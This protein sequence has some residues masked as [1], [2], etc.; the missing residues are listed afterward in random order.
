MAI[1]KFVNQTPEI[2]AIDGAIVRFKA[3]AAFEAPRAAAV[4]ADTPPEQR[5][6]AVEDLLEFGATVAATAKTSAH[7][8]MMEGKVEELAARLGDQLKDADRRSVKNIEKVLSEFQKDLVKILSAREAVLQKSVQRGARFEDI[9]SARLPLLARGIGQV[10]HCAGS[11]GDNARN[12]GDYIVTVESALAG[13][14]VKIVVEAK[15]QKA[16]FGNARIREELRT[17]RL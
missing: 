5:P 4:L 14:V 12:A 11:A 7:I 17:A 6:E 3:G 15:A 2:I 8:V 9:L 1:E 13:T 10:E 16:R